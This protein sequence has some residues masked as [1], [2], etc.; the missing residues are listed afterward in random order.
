MSLYM[1]KFRKYLTS[2]PYFLRFGID[3][4][5]IKLIPSHGP[6]KTENSIRFLMEDTMRSI[7]S[8]IRSLNNLETKLHHGNFE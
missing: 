4:L 7:E 8:C 2:A 5:T 3:A 6:K 1:W